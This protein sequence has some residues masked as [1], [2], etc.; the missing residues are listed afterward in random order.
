MCSAPVLLRTYFVAVR[1][2]P[3]VS[4]YSVLLF[5]ISQTAGVSIPWWCMFFLDLAVFALTVTETWRGRQLHQRYDAHDQ[6][7]L[8]FRDGESAT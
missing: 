3:F 6:L 7:S 4:V 1:A 5:A 2:V 8:V